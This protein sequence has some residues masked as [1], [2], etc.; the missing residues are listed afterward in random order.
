MPSPLRS[1]I[2]RDDVHVRSD[3]AISDET[4]ARLGPAI[5]GQHCDQ[6]NAIARR[7][8]TSKNQTADQPTQGEGN[9]TL[10]RLTKDVYRLDTLSRHERSILFA[11]LTQISGSAGERFFHQLSRRAQEAPA[12][13]PLDP[14]TFPL[15]TLKAALMDALI[16]ISGPRRNDLIKQAVAEI[17]GVYD[18]VHDQA[19]THSNGPWGAYQQRSTSVGGDWVTAMMLDIDP[20]ATPTEISAALADYIKRR[21][22]SSPRRMQAGGTL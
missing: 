22:A 11:C 17:A 12:L 18:Q 9:A 2:G 5:K 16:T 7:Y 14:E 19:L 4:W 3:R 6:L 10:R 1:A 13:N 20:D 15:E 8:W 21:N